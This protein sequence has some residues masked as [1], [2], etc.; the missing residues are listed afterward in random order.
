MDGVDPDSMGP[1]L[2]GEGL[3]QADDTVLGGGVVGEGREASDAGL[4][5]DQDE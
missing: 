3:H 2:G 1:Q 4:E 5:L